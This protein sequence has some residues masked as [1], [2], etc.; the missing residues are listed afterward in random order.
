MQVAP[1]CISFSIQN[2][3]NETRIERRTDSE[4]KVHTETKQVRVN[5][6]KASMKYPVVGYE[7]ETLSPDQTLAMFHLL[8]DGQV[9]TDSEKGEADLKNHKPKAMVILAHF[10]LEFNAVSA[11]ASHH[12]DFTKQSFYQR[13]TTDVHQ[14][15]KE[16]RYMDNHREYVVVSLKGGTADS[17]ETQWWMNAGAY[18]L[19][20]LA[21]MALP[22]RLFMYSQV[23]KTEWTIMKHFSHEPVATWREPPLKSRRYRTD[24]ASRAFRAVPREAS[25][26]YGAG[27]GDDGVGARPN[28]P[29]QLHVS[30]GAPAYWKNR[31]LGAGFDDKI[32]LPPADIA[33]FQ[34]IL[35]HTFKVKATRDR[36]N[37]AM[38]SRL[39]VEQVVRVEDASLWRRY[40]AKRAQLLAL[41][42]PR[43]IS[44]LPGSGAL[45]TARF[46]DL[47]G[48][49][50]VLP[51]SASD[52]TPEL[53]EGYL[54]HGSS[55]GGALGIGE[56]GFNMGLVGSNVGTMFGAGAY[57]AEAS[58]KSD[59]YASED[60]QGIF[61]GKQALILCRSLLGNPFYITASDIP[62]IEKALATGAFDSVLGDREAEVGTYREFVVFDQAQIYPEYI[63]IYSRS[64]VDT[65]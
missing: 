62:R 31:D 44:E 51:A 27:G 58:S 28:V 56:G 17:H 43:P 21:L 4:G 40:E 30:S 49:E 55:P 65:T 13:N 52:F 45:K 11:A 57:L 16:N 25:A 14:D 48:G 3:H 54:F 33:R 8:N 60:P 61:A 39:V 2:W 35:D 36:K 20:S 63:V 38:P 41:G 46:V 19:C 12:Y 22:Y 15:K 7:D 23:Q 37:Q 29:I 1:P 5:T 50:G 42:G 18:Y 59:E 24:A 32:K 6:H 9:H 34:M 64:F 10:P 26:S 53:N 47:G